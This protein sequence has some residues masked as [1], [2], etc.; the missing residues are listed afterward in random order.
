MKASTFTSNVLSRIS[1]EKPVIT[2]GKFTYG[3]FTPD[4]AVTEGPVPGTQLTRENSRTQLLLSPR[5]NT[6]AIM[7]TSS[8]RTSL[9]SEK[10][11]SLVKENINKLYSSE[12]IGNTGATTIASQDTN[13][14]DRA[15]QLILRAAESREI[16]GNF[17]DIAAD[18]GLSL[19]DSVD[20]SLLQELGVRYA[21]AGAQ[22]A[23]DR[24][25]IESGKFGQ[26]RSFTS[27]TVVAD[28]FALDIVLNTPQASPGA[29]EALQEV[30]NDVAAV[31]SIARQEN[32][33]ISS[34]DYITVVDPVSVKAGSAKTFDYDISALANVVYR[35][36]HRANGITSTKLLSVIP[37]D[38]QNFTD[39][40]V[41]YGTQYHYWIHTVYV[42]RTSAI[43]ANTGQVVTVD[44]LLQ[45]E[46]SNTISI[47]S[48][49][50]VPPP[51][52]ADIAIRWD[53]YERKPVVTWSFPP[54]PQ[55][56]I[57]YFQVFKRASVNEP[58]ELQVEYDFNDSLVKPKRYES[59]EP[60]NTK[61]VDTPVL[62][63]VD[64]NFKKESTAI[65]AVACVDARGLVSNYSA[66]IEA[67]FDKIR[68]RLST[69]YVSPGN[70]PRPYPNVFLRG[71]LFLD[72]IVTKNKRRIKAYFD[73]EYL[74]LVDRFG[75][76]MKLFGT[77]DDGTSYKI[78]VI[79]TDRA[80]DLVV[81]M[82]ITDLLRTKAD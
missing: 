15:Y 40:Q 41:M 25:R 71:D 47:H 68:N 69:K 73:P 12:D 60:T 67:S 13:V 72:S 31:Q 55:R 36:E 21:S 43:T 23:V 37:V 34:N 61:P 7:P 11:V 54:N 3:Y 53:Y 39:F 20:K 27:T 64:A 51:P 59:I 8:K 57:K 62:S 30:R 79:D 50:T 65:Y 28:K 29:S 26:A 80:E 74:K 22:F 38:S 76:D 48:S 35:K 49:E 1:L 75:N 4:E 10:A 70:A 6:I 42:M 45:S 44:I 58:F 66:Q 77:V 56:D 78:S 17:T 32:Q 19:P 33:Q 14:L 81:D 18:L 24:N 5:R 52:P 9:S 46:P 82:S 16:E 63:F 2:E